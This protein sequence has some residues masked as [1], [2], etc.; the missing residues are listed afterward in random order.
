[1]LNDASHSN[2]SKYFFL[3]NYVRMYNKFDSYTPLF[4]I[5][6]PFFSRHPVY[7]KERFDAIEHEKIS[8]HTLQINS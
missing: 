6:H 1:M 3:L 7:I 5:S 2:W 4:T 8:K